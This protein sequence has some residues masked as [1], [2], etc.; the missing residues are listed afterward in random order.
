MTYPNEV[1]PPRGP[2][3]LSPAAE[4]R[5]RELLAGLEGTLQG[6]VEDLAGKLNAV[7]DAAERIR[8]QTDA[9][10][11]LLQ[12]VGRI[13]Q[14]SANAEAT[15]A[16]IH[17]GL[18]SYRWFAAVV[19]TIWT[20]GIAGMGIVAEYRL[21]LWASFIPEYELRHQAWELYGDS[22]RDCH[23]RARQQNDTV[24]CGRFYAPRPT[25]PARQ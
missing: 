25:A 18:R 1:P 24:F 10:Q 2:H 5:L 13:E 12:G 6:S 17:R 7:A 23:A 4:G 20:A 19:L 15:L 11:R 8:V 14:A 21:G 3:D 9:G 16:R 22:I